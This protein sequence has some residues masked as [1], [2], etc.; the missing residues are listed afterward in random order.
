MDLV[1]TFVTVTALVV[2]GLTLRRP[3]A[4]KGWRDQA[5][6]LRERMQRNVFPALNTNRAKLTQMSKTKGFI[7]DPLPSIRRRDVFSEARLCGGDIVE[8]GSEESRDEN[9]AGGVD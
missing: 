9:P 2:H 8:T 7:E 3:E 1:T 5:E 4:D 6:G